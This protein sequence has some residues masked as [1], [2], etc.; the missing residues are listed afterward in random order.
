MGRGAVCVVRA[1]V[2]FFLMYRLRQAAKE[3]RRRHL[4]DVLI[5][6]IDDDDQ[7]SNLLKP[8]QITS[9]PFKTF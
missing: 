7:A 2:S 6:V 9:N 3:G 5:G 8:M 4:F 1:Y